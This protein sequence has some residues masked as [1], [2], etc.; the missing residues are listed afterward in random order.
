MQFRPCT[1]HS[2]N[3]EQKFLLELRRSM[4]SRILEYKRKRGAGKLTQ[5]DQNER[6]LTRSPRCVH[7]HVK[8]LVYTDVSTDFSHLS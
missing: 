2:F 4:S 7:L 3:W 1:V 6:K 5:A 8:L